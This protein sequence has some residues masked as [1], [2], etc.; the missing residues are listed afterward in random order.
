MGAE[1]AR[2]D[3]HPLDAESLYEKAIRSARSNGFIH[4]EAIA[5][6]R[7]SAFYRARG[8]DQ[9]AEL[10]LRNARYGYLR[11][12]ADGKVRQLEEMHPG[13]GAENA[14]PG[15]TSTI[16]APVEHLDLAT[17]IKVSQAVSGEMVLEKLID[18][19]MRTAIA[20]AGAERG[21]LILSRGAELRIEAEATIGGNTVRVELRDEP[22][23]AVALPEAVLNYVLR[24]RESVILDDAAAQSTFDADAYIRRRQAHSLL[25]L[26]LLNQAKLIGVLYLE[27]NLA[28]RVFAPAR[29]TVLKLLASQAAI[30]LENTRLYRDLAGRE[31]KIRRLVDANII[32]IVIRNNEGSILKANDAFLRIVGY[33]REDLVA[34]RLRWTD[35]TAPESRDRTAQ[36]LAEL[37]NSG[38]HKPF[39]KEY[40]RKDG[41]RVP[42]LT[43]AAIFEE[44]GNEGVA[45]VLDLTEREQAE[46]AL[47]RSEAS[48]AEGQRLT[49]TGSWVYDP[50]IGESTFWSAENFR[51]FGL[52]PL[53]GPSSEKFWRLVHPEDHDRVRERFER[54]VH[55]KREYVD[56]FR[57][58]LADGR[59]KHVDDFAHPVF[60]FAGNLVE[61]VGTTVD[62]TE[63]KRAEEALRKTQ[64][65]LAHANRVATMGQL[66]ASIAHEVS[67][68]IHAVAINAQAASLWLAAQPPDLEEVGKILARINEN[69]NRAGDVIGRIRALVKK[70]PLRKDRL[71]INEVIREVIELARGEAEKNGVSVRTQ[72]ADGLPLIQGDR[73]QL[74][75][76]ILNL[77]VNAVQAMSGVSEGARELLISTA[78][79][80]SDA[81]LVGVCDSGPGLPPSS[82]ERLFEAFYTTK[83]DGMGM[84]L[85]ICRSIIEAHGGRLWASENLPR[86]AVFQ[87]TAP[88]Y[89]GEVS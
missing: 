34:G 36:A 76:V 84:G 10:Y 24:T 65:E 11:W 49:H 79:A 15:P 63:R 87:F 51:I 60:N 27:N 16:G 46:Q 88:A 4:N 35:L 41:S 6:E 45:F 7:A 37:E 85:S 57:I 50:L 40:I 56:N 52:D 44:G 74:Q 48:L 66:T 20:Q 26:P 23:T 32:G 83:P 78:T 75:Q 73:V 86:G 1:I 5:Y 31:A 43:G 71:E 67:Q 68:P 19:L 9:I 82:L 62:V 17:V 3:G 42:V 38:T 14:A 77:I 59:V 53:E 18:T 29:I 21:L 61:Y 80:E 30:T 25:C 39:E 33:D 72:L 47:R 69:S 58:V 8:F 70:A 54:R 64:T 12:G 2:L 89:V 13:L 81:V 55:E 28:P 22:V